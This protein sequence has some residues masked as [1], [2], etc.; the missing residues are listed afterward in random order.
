VDIWDGFVD[1]N[2]NFVNQGPDFEGQTRRL[3][4][5][6]GVHFTKA[7][8]RK[9][10][11]YVEREIRRVML[12]R[13]APAATPV[14]T[15]KEVPPPVAGRPGAPARP[16]AGP[17]VPLTGPAAAGSDGLLGGGPPRPPS[18]HP[19]VNPLPG[20]GEPGGAPLG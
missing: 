1:E 2:G 18:S 13:G 10:A 12:A 17:V 8:A 9:L 7:G 15:E 14:L 3:R 5:G 16:V 20:H 19:G 6:D 11:H 4:A